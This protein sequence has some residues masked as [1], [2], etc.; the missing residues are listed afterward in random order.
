MLHFDHPDVPLRL[1]IG[2]RH[3]EIFEESQDLFPFIPESLKQI[4][5]FAFFPPAPFFLRLRR[6]QWIFLFSNLEDFLILLFNF[7]YLLFA[8]S[9]VPFFL[10]F[11]PP[12]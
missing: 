6:W 2:K 4:A 3:P 1:V 11:V 10:E 9:R 7:L 8:G 12:M 5:G